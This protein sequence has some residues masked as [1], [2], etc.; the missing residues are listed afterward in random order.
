MVSREQYT[1]VSRKLGGAILTAAILGLPAFGQAGAKKFYPDDPLVR[2]PPP[3]PVRHIAPRHVDDLYDFLDNSFATPR[4]QG[5]VARGGPH[6]ALDVNTLGDVP[7]CA[8][9]TNR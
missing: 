5:K 8:W 1:A 3:R 9:Y 7:D 2:E 4:R 6:P